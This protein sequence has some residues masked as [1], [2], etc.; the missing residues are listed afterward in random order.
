MVAS[1]QTVLPLLAPAAARGLDTGT[2]GCMLS[3][4]IANG[5]SCTTLLRDFGR[6]RAGPRVVVEEASVVYDTLEKVIYAIFNIREH[7]KTDCKL[8]NAIFQLVDGVGDSSIKAILTYIYDSQVGN[9][10]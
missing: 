8:G 10:A 7:V 9:T 6:H 4:D 3:L 5:A 1:L 2:A